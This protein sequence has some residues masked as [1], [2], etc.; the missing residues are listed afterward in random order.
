MKFI[1]CPKC[2]NLIEGDRIDCDQCGHRLTEEE[3]AADIRRTEA[4]AT[5]NSANF[6]SSNETL[7]SVYGSQFRTSRG[8][9]NLLLTVLT[10]ILVFVLVYSAQR[11]DHW[12]LY[13][14]LIV[15]FPFGITGYYIGRRT[16]NGLEGFWFCNLLGPLGIVITFVLPDKTREPCEECAELVKMQAKVCPYCGA[17]HQRRSW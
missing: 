6:T 3:R 11:Y 5:P 7:R 1:E 4:F 16:G 10:L 9:S 13:L 2:G 17:K 15:L 8:G 12:Q 14:V